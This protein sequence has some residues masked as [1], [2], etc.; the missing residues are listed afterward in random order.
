[1]KLQAC[2][3]IVTDKA[4]A[5]NLWNRTVAL[6]FHNSWLM[7][8]CTARGERSLGHHTVVCVAE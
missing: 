1:M 2:M 5:A 7:Q 4:R 6:D 8:I 3:S